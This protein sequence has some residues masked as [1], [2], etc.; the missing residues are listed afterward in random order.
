MLH[1]F[2]NQLGLLILLLFMGGTLS[3]T[4]DKIQNFK[5]WKAEQVQRAKI[6]VL[7]LQKQIK[8]KKQ[9]SPSVQTQLQNGLLTLEA[10][11][12]LT[13]TDYFAGYL[14]KKKDRQKAIQTV[15]A[16]LSKSEIEEV[17][18]AYV[19]A[20]FVSENPTSRIRASKLPSADAAQ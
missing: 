9:I 11:Q 18:K 3:A 12:D 10:A 4:Q 14:M 1:R 2:L 15:A 7:V 8:E 17:M 20:V 6:K 5:T 13:V 19:N 16:Q